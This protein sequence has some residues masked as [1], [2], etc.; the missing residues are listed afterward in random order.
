MRITLILGLALAVQGA[1]AQQ[2]TIKFATVAPEGSTWMNVMREYD[3]AVRKESGGR[4]GFKI[5]GTSVQGDEKAVLRKIRVG[6]L[7]AGGFTGMAMGEIAPKVRILDSPFLFRTY[8]EVDHVYEQYDQEFRKAFE[9]GGYILL[10]WAEVG[11]VYVFSSA[12]IHKPQDLKSLRMWSWEGDPI[13]ETLFRELDMNPIP[14][15]ITDVMTSLQTGLIDAFYTSPYAAVVLQW[16]TRVKY[17]VDV[18]LADAAGA[19]L[20]SKA[21]FDKMPPDLQ[22]ILLRNG[23]AYMKRLTELSRLDNKNAIEEMRKR[24]MTLL[25]ADEKDYAHYVEACRV[26]RWKLVGKLF[27]EDFLRRIEKT[28]EDLRKNS[29]AVK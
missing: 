11:F 27:S 5:Y 7:H 8:Q 18:Q 13:A 23:K 20:V 3:A 15:A 16:F 14:L 22:E 28:V 9:D 25:K 10:G 26:A 24:G 2:Y 19:V 21:Y 1:F 12:P 29:K 6:Q 17:M 4:V